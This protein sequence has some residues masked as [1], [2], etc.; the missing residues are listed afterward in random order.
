[1]CRKW[2]ESK[3]LGLAK[4]RREIV[5]CANLSFCKIAACAM[6]IKLIWF[7]QIVVK[8]RALENLGDAEIAKLYEV[9]LVDTAQQ[10]RE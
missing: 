4:L 9:D 6:T 1:M 5:G 10:L 2:I 7:H 3:Y 8:L